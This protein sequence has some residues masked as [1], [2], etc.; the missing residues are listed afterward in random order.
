MLLCSAVIL[1]HANIHNACFIL[2]EAT[3]LHAQQ[4]IDRIQSFI[5]VNMELF[6]ETGMLDDFSTALVK[7]LTEFSQ[8]KQTEKYPITR[9]SHLINEAL[10]KHADWLALQDIPMPISRSSHAISRK[11]SVNL[12]TTAHAGPSKSVM[13][14]PSIRPPRARHPP[15][16]KR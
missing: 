3:H 5:T 2:A 15:V 14:N 11:E 1:Q 16:I 9:S 13:H 7:Q 10:I 4:L 6:L 12:M 8:A